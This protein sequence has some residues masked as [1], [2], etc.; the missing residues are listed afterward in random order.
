[1]ICLPSVKCA[2]P[3]RYLSLRHVPCHG[4]CSDALV[5]ACLHR[6]L[7]S[8]AGRQLYSLVYSDQFDHVSRTKRSCLCCIW[9]FALFLFVHPTHTCA[10]VWWF[11]LNTCTHVHTT[12]WKHVYISCTYMHSTLYYVWL[13]RCCW[14]F[15]DYFVLWLCVWGLCIVGGGGVWSVNVERKQG[16]SSA[17]ITYTSS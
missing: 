3:K 4:G 14:V 11:T 8:L 5:G 16:A 12:S 6:M 7:Q 17:T 2:A 9:T 15:T 1:M 13:W 10:V